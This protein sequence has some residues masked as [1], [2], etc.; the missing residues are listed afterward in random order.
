M[1]IFSL[2]VLHFQQFIRKVY[3]LLFYMR[4]NGKRERKGYELERK[5][6]WKK[7]RGGTLIHT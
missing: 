6:E 2:N 5:I 3:L 4:K 7:I 1:Y